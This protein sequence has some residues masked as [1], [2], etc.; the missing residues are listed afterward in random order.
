M[1]MHYPPS[2]PIKTEPVRSLLKE[3]KKFTQYDEQLFLKSSFHLQTKNY[4]QIS[5]RRQQ[6]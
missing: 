5:L 2:R 1:S 6:T 4:S 3:K